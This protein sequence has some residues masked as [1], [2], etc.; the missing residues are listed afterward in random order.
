MRELRCQFCGQKLRVPDH[1]I[2]TIC[3]RCLSGITSSSEPS[4]STGTE[5][6][7]VIPLER[8]ITSDLW[9]ANIASL[10]LGAGI[11]AGAVASLIHGEYGVGILALVVALLLILTAWMRWGD[12]KDKMNRRQERARHRSV[13]W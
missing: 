9:Q 2:S 12:A 3:P 11:G 13:Q 1:W 10:L 8:D 7:H 5:P 6:R 4:L